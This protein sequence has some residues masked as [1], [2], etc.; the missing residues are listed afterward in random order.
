MKTKI[1]TALKVSV[2]FL[3]L[4]AA[5]VFADQGIGTVT[6][7]FQPPTLPGI[8]SFAIKF[9]FVIAALAALLFLLTGAFSWI[10]SGGNKES[11]E[12][13]REK[14]QQAIIGLVIIIAVVALAVTFEQFVFQQKICFGFTCQI[15][16]PNLITP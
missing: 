1:F 8:I 6:I 14:I 7:G 11:V 12:K 5:P 2:A 9:F 3:S 15:I 16:I 13:A 10:T 4:V